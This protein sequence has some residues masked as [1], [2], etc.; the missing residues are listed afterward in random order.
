M[1]RL[2]LLLLL[3]SLLPA[4]DARLAAIHGLLVPMRRA[5]L[6][7]DRGATPALTTVKH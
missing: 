4:A 1:R 5:P 3:P 7:G 2:L 6:T